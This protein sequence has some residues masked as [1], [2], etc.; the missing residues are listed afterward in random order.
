VRFGVV[1]PSY[2]RFG[3]PGAVRRLIAAVESLGYE[4]AWFADHVAVPGYASAWVP[5]PQLDPLVACCVGLGETTRLRFGVDVL[6][7]AYRHPLLLASM[8]ASADQLGG[9]RL[10]LGI[11]VG[12]LEGEFDA[13]GVTY[14]Q[15]GSITDETLAIM[16]AVWSEPG[17]RS[18]RGEHFSFEDVHVGTRCAQ[19]GGVPLW[20]G[21]NAR[22]A[23]RRAAALGDGWHPLWPDPKDYAR[24]RAVIESLRQASGID[25]TF[26]YSYS[27][28]RGAVLDEPFDGDPRP[29]PH[30]VPTR[31]EY[32]YV[33]AVPRAPNG[34]PRFTGT[35]AELRDDVDEC[36]RN[37]IE[38]LTLRF[39]TSASELTEDGL[40]EQM[41]RFATEVMP[42]AASH[43]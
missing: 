37:G 9:G 19:E 28:P 27:C 39:W 31:P 33:P 30:A 6:V 32:G 38:H 13:L 22:R 2:G 21:G 8:V 3:E 5:S 16:R 7:A 40:V 1:V 20:V 14:A 25:R 4:S 35:V 10:T 24:D 17:P 18:H 11:G 41:T 26:T 42:D 23:L 36:A 29:A 15:R 12:Y 43:R 34:R